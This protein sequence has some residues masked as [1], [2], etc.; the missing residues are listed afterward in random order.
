MRSVAEIEARVREVR[1]VIERIQAQVRK[2]IVGQHAMMD[3]LL[4]AV[5]TGGHVL[6]EGVPGLAKTTAVH[7][8]A[9]TM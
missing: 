1:P 9:S 7:T 8:L 3:R 5:L 6:L 2:V 4:I